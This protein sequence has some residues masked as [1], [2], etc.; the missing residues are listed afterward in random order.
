MFVW[1]KPLG[2]YMLNKSFIVCST[3]FIYLRDNR[4]LRE[5][6]RLVVFCGRKRKLKSLRSLCKQV[7]FNI[8]AKDNLTNVIYTLFSDR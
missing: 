2:L 1:A 4:R 3:V 8:A 6:T 5:W 7:Q